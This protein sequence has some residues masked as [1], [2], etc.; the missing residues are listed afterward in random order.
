MVIEEQRRH[1]RT[2]RLLKR[3][4]KDCGNPPR[5]PANC[6]CPWAA[7]VAGRVIDLA[8]WYGRPLPPRQL[9]RAREAF[10]TLRL[11]VYLGSF[12]ELGRQY[13][14]HFEDLVDQPHLVSLLH[15]T[16]IPSYLSRATSLLSRATELHD[17]LARRL[18]KA[19]R[20]VG[21]PLR[22][23]R[24]VIRLNNGEGFT[25]QEASSCLPRD[26]SYA[27]RRLLADLV[28]DGWIVQ[29][30]CD[31]WVLTD[32]GRDL[33]AESRGK[34]TLDRA[35]GLLAE[36]VYRVRGVNNG[37]DYA[38][39]VDT[40]VVFGSYLSALAKIGD[41]D[42]AI[43]LRPRSRSEA[44]QQTL[45]ARARNKAP[46]GLNMVAHICWPQTEVMRALQARSA[47]IELHD[48][49]EL[50]ALFES[51]AKPKYEVILGDWSPKKGGPPV[52]IE[53]AISIA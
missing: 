37:G 22:Q 38:Y 17:G 19:A 47:F 31:H 2:C 9:R 34:L 27:V 4:R 36:F 20:V 1:Y 21:R 11:D 32:R 46:G 30:K 35:D 18:P 39:K 23:V 44:D 28:T 16:Q 15:P 5:T 43:K 45:E 29:D 26:D 25:F 52:V 51:G 40:V 6:E 14:V 8:T 49:S 7:R 13:S 10:D 12:S 3:H 33:R 42:I 24:S 48:I 53:R 41:I 50:E